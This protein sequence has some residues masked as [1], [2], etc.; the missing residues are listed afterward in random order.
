MQLQLKVDTKAWL[1]KCGWNLA[2]ILRSQLSEQGIAHLYFGMFCLEHRVCPSRCLLHDIPC[3][4]LSGIPLI[5]QHT[6]NIF[7]E[8]VTLDLPFVFCGER[9]CS[10]LPF[11]QLLPCSTKFHLEKVSVTVFRKWWSGVERQPNIS[12][13]LLLSW[14]LR[15]HTN[16]LQH[17]GKLQQSLRILHQAC[18]Y[19]RNTV[20]VWFLQNLLIFS[21]AYWVG[22]PIQRSAAARCCFSWNHNRMLSW[23]CWTKL[24]KFLSGSFH[25]A[26][27][28]IL[29]PGPP[30][31][32]CMH[33]C[34]WLCLDMTAVFFVFLRLQSC[35]VVA[36]GDVVLMPGWNA[37]M[38]CWLISASFLGSTWNDSWN[39]IKSLPISFLFIHL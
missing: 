20:V 24:G 2:D 1:R 7:S 33:V 9:V 19:S 10:F 25:S 28:F 17:A 29:L 32:V 36:F 16:V 11:Q 5:W 35:A 4:F 6:G 37:G 3:T 27:H 14:W 8:K 18:P 34:S 13:C 23:G 21:C 26:V 31:L 39:Q 15:V 12:Q 38:V 30:L 22:R